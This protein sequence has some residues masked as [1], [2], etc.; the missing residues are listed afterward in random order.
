MDGHDIATYHVIAMDAGFRLGQV[1]FDN[2]GDI[3]TKKY[4]WPICLPKNDADYVRDGVELTE[5]FV[6]GWLDAP[7]VSQHN[8]RLLGKV[9]DSVDGVRYINILGY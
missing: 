8:R 5:G 4:I 6:V 2:D 1:G 7:P 3:D 9:S